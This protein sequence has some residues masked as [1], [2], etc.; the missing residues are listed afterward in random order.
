[1]PI[2]LTE[3]PPSPPDS[4]SADRHSHRTP[5]WEKAAVLIALVLLIFNALQTRSSYLQ[6]H[7]LINEKRPWLG[8][9]Q[10]IKITTEP[11]FEVQEVKGR[12]QVWMKFRFSAAIQNFGASPAYGEYDIFSSFYGTGAARQRADQEFGWFC[13]WV[14]QPGPTQEGMT[15]TIFPGETKGAD[16]VEGSIFIPPD[17]HAGPLGMS[18][19]ACITYPDGSGKTRHTKAL[20]GPVYLEGLP[21]R[22]V[23]YDPLLDYLIIREFRIEKSE[24]D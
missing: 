16:D 22:V 17:V 3:I 15:T 8:P 23:N 11:T 6:L 2:V 1:M 5:P 19:V 21:H 4:S 14:Q 24:T 9:S 20:Y 13:P 7:E 12:K 18:I 10:T